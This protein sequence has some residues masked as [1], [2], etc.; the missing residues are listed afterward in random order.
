MGQPKIPKKLKERSAAEW[1]AAIRGLR[2]NGMRSRVASM[3]WWDFEKV[4]SGELEHWIE[5]AYEEES[6]ELPDELVRDALER[7]GYSEVMLRAKFDKKTQPL[8]KGRNKGD[9]APRTFDRRDCTEK[10]AH[11]W[12]ERERGVRCVGKI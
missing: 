6:V 2:G 8:S 4:F 11:K 12:N 9:R 3:V 1:V 5:N 7:L 10:R